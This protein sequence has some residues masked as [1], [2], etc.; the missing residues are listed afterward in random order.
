M[1]L[2]A[3]M[4]LEAS[5]QAV[6]ISWKHLSPSTLQDMAEIPKFGSFK[7]AKPASI[8]QEPQPSE[9]IS[10]H[11]SDKRSDKRH[12]TFEKHEESKK[13]HRGRHR[14]RSQE[15][16]QPPPAAKNVP[17]R[18]PGD[19]ELVDIFV[20]DRRGDEK[21]LTYGSIHRYS[22]P[23][24][25]RYGAGY[26]LGLSSDFRIDR[27]LGDD[28]SLAIGRWKEGRTKTREKYVFSRVAKEKPRLLRIR[29]ATTIAEVT[30]EDENFVPLTKSRKRK[31][32]I[33]IEGDHVDSSESEK[34]ERDYRS[35]YGTS[36]PKD[37]PSD[38]ELQYATESDFS[39]S[40]AGYVAS[41]PIR[42]SILGRPCIKWLI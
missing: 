12:S 2:T 8:A 18:A 16:V 1:I 19:H 22:V 7:P 32:S 27:H 24:F 39:G 13:R 21:N 5:S 6:D 36:K 10:K 11:K 23:P 42:V 28:K 31:R 38:D 9:P 33:G 37:V 20:V 41:T 26:V 3:P 25:Y 29:P 15:R 14:S 17:S 30:A 40:D 34:D 4:P 35:T